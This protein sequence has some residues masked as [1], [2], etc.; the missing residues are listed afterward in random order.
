ME[1]ITQILK[2]PV[3]EHSRGPPPSE[4]QITQKFQ[5]FRCGTSPQVRQTQK[6]FE[7]GFDLNGFIPLYKFNIHAAYR[8]QEPIQQHFHGESG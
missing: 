5:F 4:S 7:A 6:L 8:A 2:F 1:R 3:V